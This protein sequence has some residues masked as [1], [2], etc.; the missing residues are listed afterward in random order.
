[1]KFANESQIRALDTDAL[2]KILL[3]TT[4]S[5]EKTVINDQDYLKIWGINASEIAAQDLIVK[6]TEKVKD[7]ISQHS[8]ELLQKMFKRGTLASALVKNVG[9]DP[10]RDDFVYEYGR[11]AHCLAENKLYG[12]GE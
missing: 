3:A 12:T 8:Q 9:A 11:L 4:H 1:M 7:K 5:A 10:D 2:A 6:I